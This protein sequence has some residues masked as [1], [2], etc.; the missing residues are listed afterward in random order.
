LEIRF[1]CEVPIVPTKEHEELLK[2]LQEIENADKLPKTF[3]Y[4]ERLRKY[5]KGE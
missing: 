5:A 2:K 4:R 3:E 1:L